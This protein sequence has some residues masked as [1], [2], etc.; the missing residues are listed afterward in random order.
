MAVI[1]NAPS[2]FRFTAEVSPER[3]LEGARLL[4]ADTQGA[5]PKDAGEVVAKQIIR[6]MRAVGMP[7]GLTGVGYTEDDVVA[8]TGGGLPSTALIAERSARDEQTGSGGPVSA[9]HA[10]LVVAVYV[11][12]VRPAAPAAGHTVRG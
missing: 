6:I 8:L 1:V 5:G 2:V 9:S 4:G 11:D 12:R 7:N 10:L 3:H